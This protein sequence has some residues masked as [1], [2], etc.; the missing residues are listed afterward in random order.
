MVTFWGCG[1][2]SLECPR[3][4]SDL[5]WLSP[6][7]GPKGRKKKKKKK[8]DVGLWLSWIFSTPLSLSLSL[9]LSL[10]ACLKVRPPCMHRRLDNAPFFPPN[11]VLFSSPFKAYWQRHCPQSIINY[12]LVTGSWQRLRPHFVWFFPPGKGGK[13]SLNF[14]LGSWRRSILIMYVLMILFL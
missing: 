11:L 12:F 10:V 6:L 4:R 9:S 7:L 14:L 2:K 3:V 1:L 5:V 13:A 8:R